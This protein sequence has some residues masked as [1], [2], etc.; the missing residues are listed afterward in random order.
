MRCFKLSLNDPLRLIDS[1]HPQSQDTTVHYY[2]YTYL[3]EKCNY[4]TQTKARQLYS[5]KSHC[6]LSC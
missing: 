2:N 3:F 1:I 5:A 6:S 4:L